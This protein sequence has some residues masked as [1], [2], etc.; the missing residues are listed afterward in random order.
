M[1]D[2]VGIVTS[3]CCSKWSLMSDR[4][5]IY[6]LAVISKGVKSWS[7]SEIFWITHFWMSQNLSGRRTRIHN[8]SMAEPS[9][10]NKFFGCRIA[11]N[12]LVNDWTDFSLPS[13]TAIIRLLSPSHARSLLEGWKEKIKH[14]KRPHRGMN[15]W[16]R[17]NMTY[18]R[19]EM[20]LY[21][22][23][24]ICSSPTTSQMLTTIRSRS[25]MS[26]VT[27]PFLKTYLCQ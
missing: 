27:N 25:T 4:N 12:S 23:F 16:T 10:N 14:R 19:L 15:R 1:E 2:D 9:Q 26:E 5:R 24:T 8:K 18:T 11:P 3:S 17:E 20:T 6:H 22:P 13:P 7:I 21:S